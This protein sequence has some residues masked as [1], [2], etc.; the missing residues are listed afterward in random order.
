M[1]W[2][3]NEIISQTDFEY[4]VE[5]VKDKK[6]DVLISHTCT[7]NSR[8]KI[9]E[10]FDMDKTFNETTSEHALSALVYIFKPEYNFFGHW[11]VNC[12]GTHDS[13]GT[14]FLGIKHDC[15][16]DVSNIFKEK[17]K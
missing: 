1:T 17:E 2:F 9:L 6:I 5:S 11:H 10:K 4:I 7:I 8:K 16:V 15:A 13:I 12:G 14:R 3:R